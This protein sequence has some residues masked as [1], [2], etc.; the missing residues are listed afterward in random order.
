MVTTLYQLNHVNMDNSTQ[1][2]EIAIHRH[3]ISIM[4]PMLDLNT[5]QSDG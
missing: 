1:Y 4:H 2:L 3:S 5:V